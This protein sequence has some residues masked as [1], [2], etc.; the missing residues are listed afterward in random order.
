MQV[1]MVPHDPFIDQAGTFF[2][3]PDPI[4]LEILANN[5]VPSHYKL[6]NR[7]FIFIFL[8]FKFFLQLF[9]CDNINKKNLK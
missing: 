7:I 6:S 9:C 1:Q 4:A 2:S 8:N 5:Q 3:F